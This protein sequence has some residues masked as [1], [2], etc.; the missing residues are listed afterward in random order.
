MGRCTG[1]LGHQGCVYERRVW[2]PGIIVSRTIEMH[3]LLF[4]PWRLMWVVVRDP[5]ELM[6]VCNTSQ[7]EAVKITFRID[8]PVECGLVLGFWDGRLVEVNVGMEKSGPFGE[9]RLPEGCDA[10]F[11]GGLHRACVCGNA[12][13]DVQDR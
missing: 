5:E 10:C 6:L 2:A 9:I 1:L 13:V 11:C 3:N 7:G 12:D 8:Q 4:G